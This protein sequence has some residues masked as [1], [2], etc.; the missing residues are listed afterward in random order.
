MF[1]PLYSRRYEDEC[2]L[3]GE[4]LSA[5]GHNLIFVFPSDHSN[6]LNSP[7][8]FSAPKIIYKFNWLPVAYNNNRH[9]RDETL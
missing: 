4:Q 5:R 3:F 6:A 9:S 1:D 8:S 7:I 2:M